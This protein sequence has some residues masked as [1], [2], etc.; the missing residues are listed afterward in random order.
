MHFTVFTESLSATSR[1]E[2]PVISANFIDYF[3][4]EPA[5]FKELIARLMANGYVTDENFGLSRRIFASL[6]Q[7]E[8]EGIFQLHFPDEENV[9]VVNST[10]FCRHHGEYVYVLY[11]A[12]LFETNKQIGDRVRSDGVL[13]IPP[14]YE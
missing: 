7:E 9:M 11:D 3:S 13:D 12:A 14:D 1:E 2:Q 5:R 10:A 4:S 8:F 6:K